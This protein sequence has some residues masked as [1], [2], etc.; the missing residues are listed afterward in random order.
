MYKEP[1]LT[2]E[3]FQDGEE[4]KFL[5]KS[6]K[7]IQLTLHAIAKKKSTG[8]IYFDDNK[9]FLKTILLTA[10]DK[11][12]WLDV[13]PDNDDNNHIVNVDSITLVMMHNGAKVQFSSS[14]TQIAVYAGHPA[15][16]LPLPNEMFRVQRRDFFRLSASIADTPLKCVIPPAS[17][18]EQRPHEI[19]IMDISVGGIA[20]I[21]QENCINLE[22]GE[23][24]PDCKIELPGVGT[25]ITTIQ[26]KNLF[27]VSSSSGAI[28]KHAGCEFKQM[29]G[30]MSMLLQKYIGLMQ[31]K[32]SR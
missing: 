2:V 4:G 17:E 3:K 20:L 10:N 8:I 28:V 22:A 11:G 15:F 6:P 5:I 1:I 19:T 27:E 29:D 9:R 14:H 32:I 18:K 21:C 13:G 30:K 31:S 12:I 25:L 26:V 7:E 24:Y 23:F 16:Y